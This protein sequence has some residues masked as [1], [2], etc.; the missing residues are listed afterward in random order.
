MVASFFIFFLRRMLPLRTAAARRGPVAASIMPQLVHDMASLNTHYQAGQEGS[1]D[2]GKRA[3]TISS[4]S[5]ESTVES[6]E[7]NGY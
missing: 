2:K 1:D 6:S 4:N 3:A 7:Q 5:R